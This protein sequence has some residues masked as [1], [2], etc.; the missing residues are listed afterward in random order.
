MVLHVSYWI[1]SLSAYMPR[2]R[3]TGSY[4]DSIFVF[5]RTLHAVPHRGCP[6]L[7]S[8]RQGRNV[9]HL[10]NFWLGEWHGHC[11]LEGSGLSMVFSV[12]WEQQEQWEGCGCRPDEREQKPEERH[13]LREW[14]WGK[15][16]CQ[17][18]EL[19][20]HWV[21]GRGRDKQ[22]WPWGWCVFLQVRERWKWG[23]G[24]SELTLYCVEVEIL[25]RCSL[26]AVKPGT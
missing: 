22:R 20:L 15:M 8:P 5:L 19:E 12:I 21:R 24:R 13:Q 11:V 4:S 2:S 6:N 23:V 17:L 3:I 16:L 25:F 1:I 14:K 9:Q 7:P 10:K 18:E 26:G